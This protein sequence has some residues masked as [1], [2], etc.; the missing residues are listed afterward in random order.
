MDP[1]ERDEGPGEAFPPIV[2]DAP[3][4]RGLDARARR[5]IE[6]AGRLLRPPAGAPVFQAGDEGASFFVVASGKI[7]LRALRRGDDRESE[8]RVAGPG[9]SFGEES[10]VGL[11]RRATAVAVERAVVAEIP[12][13]V[14]R[15]AAGRAGKS[16]VADRIERTLQ[17]AA[18]ADLLRTLAFTR[19]LAPREIDVLLDAIAL[20]RCDRGQYVYR[21]GEPATELFLVA[22]GLVQLQIED[23]DRLHVRAYLG[24]GDFFGDAEIADRR[25]RATSA[26]ASGPAVLLAV[27]AR[28]FEGLAAAHPELVARLRR[29]A[30]GLEDAQ[31]A[32]VAPA[33]ANATQHAFR[34]LYRLQVARS[35]LVIDLE[36]CV[37]CGHCAWACEDLHGV[38]RLVRRGDKIVTRVD[39]A[40]PPQHLLLPNSCQHCENPACMVDCPTG[41]IGRDPE[42]EVFIREALCT[43]CGACARA[44]PWDNIQMAPRPIG[45]LSPAGGVYAELAVKCDL[46]HG[47]EG[48]ACVQAC[49]TGSVFRMNPAEEITDV[50]MLLRADAKAPGAKT[51]APRPMLVAGAAI[52]AAGIGVAG[53]VLGGRGLLVPGHGAGLAAGV[54]AGI[55][56][57][58]LTAYAVPKRGIRFWMRKRV[59][60]AAAEKPASR[61]RPQLQIHVAL[62]LV[63]LGVALAHAP[64][65]RGAAGHGAA[66]AL[67]LFAASVAGGF[68]AL[69]YRLI[70]PRLA[71]LERTASL[72]EDFSRARQDLMDRL[73]RAASGKS[74]LVKKLLEKILLPY[75]R[76]PIGPLALVLSGRGLRE[77]EKALSARVDG[78][79]E[80]RGKERLAG[81]AELVRIVVELR[82]LPAQRGL[83]AILRVG[84]PIH[85]VTFGIALA[86]LLMHAGLAMLGRE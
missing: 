20:R 10:T 76:S 67:A 3:V 58:A 57:L 2:F 61:V 31:R 4:L 68:A 51:E 9:E 73:Y 16:E 65:L 34:D 37:R 63:T 81:L 5:E 22:D 19:D 33:A 15:R 56:M 13:H 1:R 60:G 86:L 12:V 80:G 27:P 75:A 14:F 55:G 26:V 48:P 7:A 17:R 18:T 66:L 47:Y 71:R 8:V 72:P 42:G 40:G 83:L 39:G 62:G 29:I 64:V 77:E 79:L 28:V 50:R 59:K 43:G 69:A 23:G 70:P 30:E 85:V 32:V 38:A 6:G 45:A 24:R 44:C 11:A 41:A 54:I 52:A 74:D 84:L 53:V 78:V 35:L 25:P 21:Q 36:S 49:P 82:A 46:C